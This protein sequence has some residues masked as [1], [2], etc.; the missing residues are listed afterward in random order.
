MIA[1][2][3]DAGLPP[4]LW[5]ELGNRLRVTLRTEQVREIE[6]DATDQAILAEL[7]DDAGR[8]T[9]Q[10]AEAIGLSPRATRTRLAKLV[11]RGLV[12]EIGSGPRDPRRRYHRSRR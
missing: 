4:P 8:S 1:A 7:G 11:D 10:L 12:V 3:R 6:A 2:C 5:E 9:A